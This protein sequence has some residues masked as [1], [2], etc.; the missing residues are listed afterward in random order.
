[1]EAKLT[2]NYLKVNN[3]NAQQLY[4]VIINK[5]VYRV[6]L[7][8]VNEELKKKVSGQEVENLVKDIEVDEFLEKF[9]KILDQRQDINEKSKESI[10]K[11]INKS[12]QSKYFPYV[13]NSPKYGSNAQSEDN[14]HSNFFKLVE[15]VIELNSKDEEEQSEVLRDYE[16]VDRQCH[17]CHTYKPTKFDITHKD[18]KK[19]RLNSKYDYLFMGA[20]N[21]T[22]SNYFESESSVCFVCEFFSLMTLLYFSLNSPRIIAYANDLVTLQFINYKVLLKERNFREKGLYRYLGRYRGQQIQL[23]ET[24]IDSNTGIIL[25]F[26]N[27]LKLDEMLDDLKLYDLVDRFHISQDRAKKVE[28]AK[29]FIKN[30]NRITM[31]K[32]LFNELLVIENINSSRTLDLEQSRDN[33]G[34]YLELLEFNHTYKGGEKKLENGEL[35]E[36]GIKLG[37]KTGEQSKKRVSFRLIQ[38]MKSENREGIFQ[39]LTHYIVANQEDIPKDLPKII[40][41]SEVN[42]LHYQIGGFLEGLINT[43]RLKEDDDNEQK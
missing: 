27:N 33:I 26:I 18:E 39:D 21:N 36:L 15:L 6:F 41:C 24:N 17:V 13:R 25:K 34:L 16:A 2:A 10:K 9:E 40:M 1:M 5:L 8:G 37:K 20:Q 19:E 11:K 22:Y 32:L 43:K 7:K 23:Y 12:F 29:A 31:E 14:F 35:K 4:D 30:K 3:L 42:E 38:M 28:I